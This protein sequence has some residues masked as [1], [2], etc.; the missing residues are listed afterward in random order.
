[1]TSIRP[2]IVPADGEQ[3]P[4][5]YQNQ[6][7]N[8]AAVAL[9]KY[10]ATR[11]SPD[12]PYQ[13][14]L[15]VIP[16]GPGGS[17]VDLLRSEASTLQ[18]VV[19]SNWD[20]V[21][22][23]PRG[24][25]RSEPALS[26]A[27]NVSLPLANIRRLDAVP[28]VSSSYYNSFLDYGKVLG[29]RCAQRSGA[30]SDAGPHMSTA[31]NARDLVSIVDA[32]ARTS[33]SS[34][35]AKNTSLLNFYAFS[36]GTVVGQTFASMFPER[37]GN[38]VL[39]GI[40]NPEKYQAGWFEDSINHLDGVLASF[41][42]YCSKAGPS[43]CSYAT[44][45]SSAQDTFARFKASF[46]RLDARRAEAEHWSNATDIAESLIAL[47][48]NALNDAY[49]PVTLFSNLAQIL[50]SLETALDCGTLKQWTQQTIAA[51]G[52]PGPAGV[53]HWEYSLGVA[54]SD[55]KDPY[56]TRTLKGFKPHIQAL[57]AQSII[58]ELW[59]RNPLGCAGWKIKSNDVFTGQ[60]GGGTTTPILF[61]SN[62]YDPVTPIGKYDQT[63]YTFLQLAVC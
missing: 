5:D 49:L 6:N 9:L 31:V 12:G 27:L 52:D 38:A 36:Y 13:G 28:R 58:G 25:Y 40:V 32:Y 39:D 26:C 44:A 2:D 34:D 60:Y 47:K 46:M 7:Q 41:F 57:E 45:N 17:G 10:A 63:P 14:M 24:I 18:A 42:I 23:D 53:I 55:Q 51:N 54:C 20:I 11:N 21:S 43:L 62:T 48:Y 59:I 61:V 56:Y 33:E 1:M 37:V 4:L 22:Y 15:M 19:G 50:V 3:T 35:A 8:C 16:G 29:E 30:E